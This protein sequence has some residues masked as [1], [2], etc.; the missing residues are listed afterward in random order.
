MNKVLLA[1][2]TSALAT[3]F[4]A[5][6][7]LQ[8]EVSAGPFDKIKKGLKK[9]KKKK[10]EAEQAVAEA[11]AVV[12]TVDSVRR[13]NGRTVLGGAGAG[14]SAA[15]KKKRGR[16]GSD[17]NSAVS[18]LSTYP[19][20]AKGYG[21]AGRAGPAPA[22]LTKLTKCAGIPIK[23]AFV[24]NLGEYTFQNGLN[25]ESRRGLIN[26]TPVA[27]E[28]GC[29]MP[30]MG[31][32]DTL[33]IEVPTSKLNAVKG[34]WKMQ[35]VNSE[36]G[37]MANSEAFPRWYNTKGKDVML[38]TGNSLGYT[39]TASGSNSD[40]STAWAKDLKR[41]G[42]SMFGFNMPNLHTDAGTDFYCQ[43]YNAESG[44]SV[45]AFQYRRSAA[46]S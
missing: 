30:S 25:T 23:N 34:G 3:G 37:K 32:Y 36:T 2:A 5:A 6:T 1:L 14:S 43:Y 13:S 27:P 11:E 29:I 41:R 26:R 40:R 45:V 33:Y 20:T 4:V 8:A 22:R 28:N 15:S 12:D 44:M 18:T 38:H 17:C 42:M 9:A 39:P 16:S 24:G 19:C 21:H 10:K 7:P 35:C 31:T 46:N